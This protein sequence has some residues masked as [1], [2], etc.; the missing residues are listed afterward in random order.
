[1]PSLKE[2]KKNF[3]TQLLLMYTFIVFGIAINI[4]EFF[5]FVLVWP[6]NRI[7]YRKKLTLHLYETWFL[8]ITGGTQAAV[9]AGHQTVHSGVPE[10]TGAVEGAGEGD[11]G[12]G[13]QE[14][15]GVCPGAE[16][17]R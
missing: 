12:G 7:L 10:A 8:D 1:M 15:P 2:F 5:T 11:H 6:F 17:S 16:A 13:E 14:D 3:F 9:P 4:L